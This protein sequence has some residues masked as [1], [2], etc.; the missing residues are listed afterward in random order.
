M[1]SG[2]AT[3]GVLL[4]A[5]RS[6][7]FFR[8]RPASIAALLRQI[9][10][11]VADQ[12]VVTTLALL[13]GDAP[14][15]SDLRQLSRALVSPAEQVGKQIEGVAGC[16]ASGR[17]AGTSSVG[18]ERGDLAAQAVSNTIGDS[19]ISARLITFFRSIGCDLLLC[20]QSAAEFITFGAQMVNLPSLIGDR[21]RLVRITVPLR[22]ASSS[23]DHDGRDE[24]EPESRIEPRHAPL[25]IIDARR[26]A[27][28]PTCRAHRLSSISTAAA[29][30]SP[31]CVA[32]RNLRNPS[33][34]PCMLNAIFIITR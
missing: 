9:G 33:S 5:S 25:R 32:A 29:F 6:P 13:A 27:R 31:R 22:I 8:D 15:V 16:R 10:L 28:S 18:N 14:L 24:R 21:R 7:C 11:R 1:L 12:R 34:L 23:A 3:G 20:H 19:S 30:Q 2:K 26:F 4:H 17:S